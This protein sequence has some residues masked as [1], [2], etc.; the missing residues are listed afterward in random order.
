MDCS[1]KNPQWASVSFGS[2]ICL[3]CSGVHRS[4]GVHL[5]FVRS[6]GMDSWSGQLIRR[7]CNSEGTAKGISSWLKHGGVRK[8]RRYMKYDSAAAEAFERKSEWKRMEEVRGTGEYSE[9]F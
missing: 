4:L 6:V 9:R 2:F 1:T 7:R 8:T 5:S 3:E